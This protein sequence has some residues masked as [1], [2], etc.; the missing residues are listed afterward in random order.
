MG[1]RERERERQRETGRY[2]ERHGQRQA[3]IT[4]FGWTI[5][6]VINQLSCRNRL[7]LTWFLPL[8][9]LPYVPGLAA[10]RARTISWAAVAVGARTVLAAAC[11]AVLTVRLINAHCQSYTEKERRALPSYFF[12]F[13]NTKVEK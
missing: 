5:F 2:R 11:K 10:V 6:C 12:F 1:E 4:C 9:K 13:F 7:L 3:E 8:T